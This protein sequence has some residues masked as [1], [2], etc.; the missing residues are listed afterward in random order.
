MAEQPAKK[1]KGSEP[2]SA[3]S[4][5]SNADNVRKL[6]LDTNIAMLNVLA[7]EP[8]ARGMW[9]QRSLFQLGQALPEGA[10]EADVHSVNFVEPPQAASAASFAK[11]MLRLP[12]PTTPAELVAEAP[13]ELEASQPAPKFKQPPAHKAP[14]P[15]EATLPR[16]SSRLLE[17][18]V[19]AKATAMAA[20]ASVPA[21]LAKPPAEALLVPAYV[22]KPPAQPLA[23]T[24]KAPAEASAPASSCKTLQ[25]KPPPRPPFKPSPP[26][27]LPDGSIVSGK[28]GAVAQPKVIAPR[29][30]PPPAR[31]VPVEPDHPPPGYAQRAPKVPTPPPPPPPDKSSSWAASSSSQ[32]AGGKVQKRSSLSNQ[33]RYQWMAGQIARQN[34]SS[35]SWDSGWQDAGWQDDDHQAWESGWQSWQEDDVREEAPSA[36]AETEFFCFCWLIYLFCIVCLC[37]FVV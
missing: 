35:S 18:S 9:A 4:S 21:Y 30:A 31:R 3:P 20:E 2:A 37:L 8:T 13:V 32:D 11:T 27:L 33:K 6:M 28:A 25:S 22:A 36:R 23:P 15:A 16:P 10:A 19:P 29:Q 7:C 24:S 12:S 26:V 14:P 1:A 34:A 17:A 5:A